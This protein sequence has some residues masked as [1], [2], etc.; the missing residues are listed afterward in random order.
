MSIPTLVNGTARNR[1]ARLDNDTATQSL[2]VPD[3]TQVLWTRGGASPEFSQ[4]A[5]EKSMDGGVTWSLLGSGTRV[6]ATANWQFTGLNLSGSGLIRAKGRT[7]GGYQN[8]SSGLVEQIAPFTLNNTPVVTLTGANPLT[9]E[10]AASYTDPGATA[11]DVEDG[12]LTPSITSN[13]VVA[14]VPSTY[15]VTW[16]AT[17]TSN[18][19]GSATRVVN[20]VDTTAPVVAVHANV[21]ILATNAAGATVNY[22]AATASDVVGITSITYSKNSGTVFPIGVTTVT[23]TARDAANNTGTGTFTVTVGNNAPVV[24]LTGANPLTFEAA[25]SYTDPGATATDV[26]DGVRT[27]SITSNTVV[28]NAPGAYAVTW[29]VTDTQ[30]ATG[31]ATRVVNVVDTTAPVVAA[32]GNVSVPATSVAGAVVTYAAA[33]ATDIVTASPVITYSQNSGTLFPIGTT[34]VTIT[35]KDAANNTGTG[36]FTVTVGKLAQSITFNP[37]AR[38]DVSGTLT[39]S[40]TGGASGNPVTFSIV[41]GPGSVSG[42]T[43]TFSAVG[44]VVVRASQAGD[45]NY[46]AATPVNVTIKAV[47]NTAPVAVDD[48]VT[49]TTGDTTLYPLANDTDADGDL[50]SIASV[51]GAGVTISADGRGLTIPLGT[52]SFTYTVTD[53]IATDTGAVTVSAGAVVSGS[54]FWTGLLYD[55]DGAVVGRAHIAGIIGQN[56]SV[57]L[58]VGSTAAIAKFRLTAPSAEVVTT[59]GTFTVNVTGAGRLDVTL[60]SGSNTFSGRLRPANQSAPRGVYHVALA[61]AERAVVPGG[62][63]ARIVVG[64]DGKMTVTCRLPD[65][66]TVTFNSNM[67]DNGSFTF[68]G[69]VA[70]TNPRAAVS[71]ECTMANLSQTDVTGE[72]LWV[73]PVQSP[74]TGLH[75]TGVD[76]VL[77]ANG[78]AFIAGSALPN[79]A[80]SVHLAGGNLGSE[81]NRS[82]TVVP[83]KASATGASF[84]W[85]LNPKSPGWI[86]ATLTLPGRTNPVIGGGLYLPKSNRVWGWFPGTTVGGYFELK[87]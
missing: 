49:T 4:V 37:P 70:G 7:V 43:L 51:S 1:I 17:D 18:A 83:G 60:K 84:T 10:A 81:I 31:S 53:G 12:T 30:S 77:T 64:V 26:E 65:T 40:A 27:P 58:R 67:S 47:V 45:A 5:F 80:V 13:T 48:S 14:N 87:P 38:A 16:S 29:T 73:K 52:P 86:K 32:H 36:T 8:G 72:L 82:G 66:K 33:N 54:K 2:T 46:E 24:T 22:A 21:S 63:V 50:L 55:A 79:G 15:A 6:G 71:G 85:I 68:Y 25:A 28:S 20:V 61:G 56:S 39:L 78:S 42:N 11:T 23:I 44:N 9:F 75:R 19:T 59:L 41:S 76:T 74:A 62:G 57:S 34:T 3:M 35:A 69:M